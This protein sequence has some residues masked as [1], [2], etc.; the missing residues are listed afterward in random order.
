MMVILKGLYIL[1]QLTSFWKILNQQAPT[2]G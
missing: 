2:Y 1:N